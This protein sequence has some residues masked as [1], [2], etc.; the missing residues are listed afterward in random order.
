M[1]ATSSHKHR[2]NPEFHLHHRTVDLIP[3]FHAFSCGISAESLRAE[4]VVMIVSW[5]T[6]ADYSLFGTMAT[7]KPTQ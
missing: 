1:S 6:I 5:I 4:Y 3:L 7:R 2:V